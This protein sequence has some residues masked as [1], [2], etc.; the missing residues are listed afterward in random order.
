MAVKK[1]GGQAS[2][3]DWDNYRNKKE[4]SDGTFVSN[5]QSLFFDGSYFFKEDRS[6]FLKKILILIFLTLFG[7]IG[8]VL[9]EKIGLMTAY[10]FSCIGSAIGVVLAVMLNR[11]LF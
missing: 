3:I 10:F 2:T 11:K 8:W 7:W 6:I 5:F 1:N 9:G 4:L